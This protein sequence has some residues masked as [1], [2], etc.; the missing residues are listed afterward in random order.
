M[1]HRLSTKESHFWSQATGSISRLIAVMLL[2]LLP[3]VGWAQTS[4][5]ASVAGTVTDPQAAVVPGAKVE[6]RNK[7]TN[8][9]QQQSANATGQY[10]FPSVVP[11]DYK[12]T[13]TM[14]GFRTSTIDPLTVNVAR[15]YTV[16]IK[17]EAGNL[18]EVVTV[19]AEARLELQTSDSTV[20]NVIAGDRLI[21][22]PA[23][24]RQVNELLAQ[25][26]LAAVATN[27]L[28]GAS[29]AVAGARP[30]QNTITLD[31]IDVTDNAFGGLG[32]NIF[33]PIDSIEE[34]RVGVATPNANFGRGAGGQVSLLGRSGAKNYHGAAFWY[35]Q[36]DNLN[37]NTWDRNRIG[38]K[39]PETKD[40]RFGF[41]LGGPTPFLWEDRTFFF[42][43]YEG[44]RFPRSQQVDRLVPTDT[45]RQGILRF[46][47][48]AGNI[49]NYNLATST[50]CGPASNTACDPRGLG[51]SPTI[52]AL[53]AKLPAGNNPNVVGV[54]G[55]NTTGFT[56]NA[57]TPINNDFYNLRLDHD[58]TKNWH[59]N[60][61]YRYFGQSQLTFNQVDI[62]GGDAKSVR[63]TPVRQNMLIAGLTGQIS[64]SLTGDFRFGW[65]RTRNDFNALRPNIGAT[66]L[67]I[68]GTNTP[69]GFIALDIGAAQG[70]QSLLS[71]PIDVGTQVARVQNDDNR[72]FQWNADMNWVK[73]SQTFQFGSHIRYLPTLHRR[74]DKV[75]G[76]VGAFVAQ[77][78]AGPGSTISIPSARRPAPCA[79]ALTTNCL[80]PGD[81]SQWD[82]LYT[83]ALGLLDQVSILGVRDGAFKPLPFGTQLISD[84]KIWSPE[85][86]LQDV[87]RIKPSLT[88]TLG[89]NY[90]WQTPP[91]DKDGRQT[92]QIDGITGQ[93]ITAEAFLKARQD[94]ASRGIIYNPPLGF[95]PINS[96]GRS[97]YDIDWHNISPRAAVAWTPNKSGGLSGK[98]FGD[99][100]TVVRGGFSVIYDRTNT[101]QSV[102]IPALGVGFA[103]T[104]NIASPACNATGAGGAGCVAARPIRRCAGSV[105]DV[106]GRFQFL[107]SRR[108]PFR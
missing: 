76:A 59:S 108:S 101:V 33:L 98:L 62:T 46:R 39:K 22:L 16:D 61:A 102:I 103:Q 9:S 15:S 20:G 63:P 90:G 5:T 51:L 14:N 69:S 80:Q 58:V 44:R 25:Q 52:S 28:G 100:K 11:G 50:L 48:A 1:K 24:T 41:A 106:M 81:V 105:W 96:A 77:L 68:P 4:T 13:V 23:L 94:A 82:R 104:L 30:D 17:L 73:G 57:R 75:F 42:A 99:G 43:N 87:W 89:I 3:G 72:N 84:T 53:W 27:A 12:L 34:Y 31:G 88:L 91:K 95:L 67:N 92:I 47:D 55:L 70:T 2:A 10:T 56:S 32:T 8:Q 78:D 71:E 97:L 64:S 21:R 79:A 83:G 7:E 19:A 40:N 18:T 85:F 37:A 29:P 26:P 45:L 6:L 65:V 60:V 49:V 74:D 66:Q 38:L 93:P 35:H 107:P 86:Y 54:D 36:N